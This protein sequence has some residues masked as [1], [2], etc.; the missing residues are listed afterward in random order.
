MR[1]GIITV[2]DRVSA[3]TAVDTTGPALG[4]YVRSQPGWLVAATITVPDM[5]AAIQQAVLAMTDTATITSELSNAPPSS[6]SS[7]SSPPSSSSFI[8]LDLILTTGGTG[9]GVRDVTPEAVRPLLHKE[10][11][12]L[13]TAMLVS[14]LAKTHLAALSRP[15]CGIRGSSLVVTLPGSKRGALENLTA[16]MSVLPHAVDLARGAPD[17]GEAFHASLKGGHQTLPDT[18]TIPLHHHGHH[19]CSRFDHLTSSA[20]SSP[21]TLITN[22]LNQPV[23]Q[24]ARISPFSMIDFDDALKMVL[25]HSSDA[26]ALHPCGTE[27]KSVGPDLLGYVLAEDVYANE[28]VPAYRASIVDGYAV[29]A[30]DGPGEYPVSGSMTA[31]RSNPTDVS[32]GVQDRPSIQKGQISRISTGAQIPHNADAVVMVECTE[33]VHSQKDHSEES[34]VRILEKVVCGQDIREIGS[35][36]AKGTRILHSGEVIQPGDIGVL[37]SCGVTSVKVKRRP[38]VAIMSSGNELVDAAS[39]MD[40][41][42]TQVAYVRDSNRPVLKALLE[43]H[44][45]NVVDLGIAADTR[46][47]ISECLRR[48]VDLADVVVSTGG[49]SM[50]EM[51]LLKP[52]L[53]RDMGARILFGRVALKPGKPTTF[54]VLDNKTASESGDSVLTRKLFFALPGNPVSTMV[55]F[56]LFVLPALRQ[57]SGYA[58][59]NLPRIN[60]KLAHDIRLDPRPEFHRARL[61]YS[62][63][64]FTAWGTGS[65]RSSRMQSM[66]SANAL[67]VLPGALSTSEAAVSATNP[68]QDNGMIRAGSTIE[69]I[70]IGNLE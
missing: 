6:S 33:L 37:C 21:D 34:I 41:T 61:A 18:T 16:L 15:V 50:G 54:A 67:L 31:G 2:S 39:T 11:P 58:S 42:L 64:V 17:A 59:P 60:V 62:N 53:E 32:N 13:V 48:G 46:E 43:L 47:G 68:V 5:V 36:V 30:S 23:T 35:D 25:S 38:V 40:S 22:S 57:M 10:A 4:E 65:Q 56:Y 28:N 70:L 1:V 63:G 27:T 69:A 52:I 51:D 24:R 7:S 8:P 19:N 3:A 26:A 20:H 14:G 29:I 44:G 49:V 9:F 55:T 66:T 12:G 45:F